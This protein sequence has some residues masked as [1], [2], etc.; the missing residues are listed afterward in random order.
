MDEKKVELK[1]KE[2]EERI[3]PSMLLSLVNIRIP[4]AAVGSS[5][6]RPRPA[7]GAYGFICA[8]SIT[9]PLFP[10]RMS[11]FTSRHPIE[12]RVPLWRTQ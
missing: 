1:I 3:A 6:Q 5:P 2:L 8:P 9:S 7:S 12:I 4:E 11:R 10:R